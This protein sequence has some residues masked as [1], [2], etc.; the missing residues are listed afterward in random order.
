VK[1]NTRI[2]RMILKQR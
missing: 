1:I 2:G